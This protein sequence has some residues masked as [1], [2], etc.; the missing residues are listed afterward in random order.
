MPDIGSS[1]TA[2]NTSRSVVDISEEGCY[3]LQ[4]KGATRSQSCSLM[5]FAT[6]RRLLAAAVFHGTALC[7]ACSCQVD[8]LCCC[9]SQKPA[10]AAKQLSTRL[11][12]C[13]HLL[14]ATPTSGFLQASARGK[15]GTCD[16]R[17][18]RLCLVVSSRSSKWYCLAQPSS[19]R[20]RWSSSVRW[21]FCTRSSTWRCQT[22]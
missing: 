9:I 3:C 19:V 13:S 7:A 10:A 22:C 21:T 2:I 16:P 14:P 6:L 4:M 12:S 8:K 17:L 18:Y 5:S 15:L 1:T 11:Y 20:S